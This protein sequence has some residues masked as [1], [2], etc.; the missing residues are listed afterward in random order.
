LQGIWK[1]SP[2]AITYNEFKES[3]L[4]AEDFFA[5]LFWDTPTNLGPM[6]LLKLIKGI[7]VN[8]LLSILLFFLF[9][10]ASFLLIRFILKF[11]INKA[12][13]YLSVEPKHVSFLPLNIIISF[14]NF[15]LEHLGLFFV[16][17]FIAL[18]IFFDFK[19]IFSTIN[20]LN[21]S[22]YIAMFYLIT[23]PIFVYLS[24]T[25]LLTLKELNRRLS[26]L[27]F[28]EKL[29]D[30]FIHLITFIC[31][32]T[33]ILMPLRFAFLTYFTKEST[34]FPDVI[35]AAYTLILVTVFLLFFSK[36]DV[37][38]LLP[39][40]HAFFIWLKAQINK[41]YYP[42]FIFLMGILI[43]SNPY[44]GYSNLAWYLA[45]II[46][47]TTFL[48]YSLFVVHHFIRKYAVFLFMRE[49]EE[50]IIDKFEHA[51][52]YYG[53]LVITSFL[54]LLLIT[55]IFVTRLWDISYTPNDI[56]KSLSEVWVVPIGTEHKF[57]F[58]QLM[59]VVM[60]ITGGFFISSTI[61][62]FGLN[63]LYD[64]LKTQPGTQ[65]T[66]SKILH[67]MI[68]SLVTVL[69]FVS[70]HLEGIIWY[71]GTVSAVGL[72]FALKD[73]FTDYVAGF[74]V[75]IERPLEIGNFVRI[76]HHPDMLGTVHKI[77]ARTTTIMTRLNHSIVI[78]NKDLANKP[79]INWGKGRFAV[80]FE[81][82]I[83]VDYNV[84][85]DVV[86]ETILNVVQSNPTILRV[87]TPIIRLEDFEESALYFLA[88]AFISS[89]RV[90]EQWAIAGAIRK[91]LI[92]VFR[93]KNIE[94]AFPQRVLH[95]GNIHD[96]ENKKPASPI[97]FNFGTK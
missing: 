67:Y 52:T 28:A 25:F 86:S 43:L 48:L 82:K 51:K 13:N 14:L 56:W 54:L 94:F 70:I 42:V 79:I 63:K 53:I 10:I 60:F 9:L 72:G 16:W 55:F 23:I 83:T 59:T 85:P 31:Y 26:F 66:I 75:L 12:R 35:M 2:K 89:R 73:I 15:K 37:L 40:R 3:L 7:S 17:F 20:F 88:R 47:S 4:E 64:I 92:L 78:P 71:F 29:Q 62:K 45:F 65:N 1:R 81:M 21:K 49:E 57:G 38:R 84:N 19:Y 5:K 36:E 6:T 90:R 87:P 24:R 18:H 77:D 27:F 30:R 46:P 76:D 32:S 96:G 34:T 11:T 58:V 41:R 44:I 91:E 93:E 61:H 39:S 68:I 97:D 95:M 74:F 22:Y 8:I 33:A 50:E 69:G 80:G